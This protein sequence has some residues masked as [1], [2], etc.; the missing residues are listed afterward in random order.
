MKQVSLLTLLLGLC[1]MA[2]AQIFKVI[3]FTG[4]NEVLQNGAW[5]ELSYGSTLNKEDKVKIGDNGY[6][7]LI[8]NN[9]KTLELKS[10]GEFSVAELSTKL[11]GGDGN[12]TKEYADFVMDGISGGQDVKQRNDVTGAVTRGLPINI[13]APKKIFILSN[14]PV[15]ITW[16]TE[17]EP[18]TFEIKLVTRFNE[19]LVREE[20]KKKS[21]ELNPQELGLKAGEVYVLTIDSKENPSHNKVM[22]QIYVAKNEQEIIKEKTKLL[23]ELNLEK[24]LDNVLLANFYEKNGLT[25]YAKQSFEKAMAISPDTELYEVAYANFMT[26]NGLPIGE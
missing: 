24:P 19:P 22:Y 12:F 13:Q 23:T 1:F 14:E 3:A 25:I 20:T 21:F 10:A 16:V 17:G 26:R 18:K 5:K 8:H 4:K 15:A 9:G 6:L 11:N 2:N 7:A